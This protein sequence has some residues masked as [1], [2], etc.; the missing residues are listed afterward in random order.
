MEI[1]MDDSN[2][3]FTFVKSDIIG[4]TGAYASVNKYWNGPQD[5]PPELPCRCS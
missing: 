4:D 2:S 3:R 5:M 1:K